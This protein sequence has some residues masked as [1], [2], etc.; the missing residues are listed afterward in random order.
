LEDLVDI[1]LLL[2]EGKVLLNFIT[3]GT[4]QRWF[5][6]RM[7]DAMVITKSMKIVSIRIK[8]SN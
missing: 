6:E 4:E 3:D 1:G 5:N 8:T 7:D 2:G